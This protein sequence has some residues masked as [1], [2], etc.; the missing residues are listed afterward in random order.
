MQLIIM[1]CIITDLIASIVM[2][3]LSVNC[4]MMRFPALQDISG[5]AVLRA[6]MAVVDALTAPERVYDGMSICSD[7]VR[8]Q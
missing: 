8:N 1:T 7:T 6:Y 5:L 2:S 3:N 4:L